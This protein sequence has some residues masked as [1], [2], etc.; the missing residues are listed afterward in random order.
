MWKERQVNLAEE[1]GF[2]LLAQHSTALKD[3]DWARL[4]FELD[5]T[6]TKSTVWCAPSTERERIK[7][8]I[9]NTRAHRRRQRIH[10]HGAIADGCFRSRHFRLWAL[11]ALET[12]LCKRIPFLDPDVITLDVQMPGLDG[13]ET[14]HRIMAGVPAGR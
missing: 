12:K 10:A 6:W 9:A 4:T 5:P 3:F 14:L 8:P 2:G 1:S 13:L 11:P 7:A